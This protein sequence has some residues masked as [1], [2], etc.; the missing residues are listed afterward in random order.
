MD[1]GKQMKRLISVFL[2][3]VMLLACSSCSESGA[4][5]TILYALSS[6]PST[7]DPQFASE[8]SAK[9]VIN[10]VFEGLVRYD[11]KGEIIP[12]IAES[13]SVS[14]DGLTYTFNLKSDTEWFCPS[15]LKS[16][17]GEELYGRFSAET[18]KARDFVFAMRRAVMPSTASPNAHRLSVIANASEIIAGRAS[19]TLLGVEAKGDYTLE[20]RLA[21][22]CGDFLSRLTE[23]VCMPCNED[24]FNAMAGRYGLSSKYIMCNG[25]FYISAWDSETSLTIK[26]NKYYAGEQEVLPAS[27]AFSFD[28]S[29]ESVASKL[30]SGDVSAAVIS[31]DNVLPENASIVKESANTVAGFVFNC[32]DIY[33]KSSALRQ[34]LSHAIDP[35]VFADAEGN[36]A[37]QKGLVPASCKVGGYD[38]RSAVGSQTKQLGFD[39]QT[40]QKLWNEALSTLAVSKI[41]LTVLCPDWL[42]TQVRRQ[43]QLWQQTFGIALAVTVEVAS[44]ADIDKAV[45]SG[46]YQIALTGIDAS[47]ESA[48][49]FLEKF[50]GGGIFRYRSD[51]YSRIIDNLY[52]Y[53][54]ND[55][56]LEGCYAAETLLLQDAVCY[57]LYSLSSYFALAPDAADITFVDSES[58]VCFINAKRFD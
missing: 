6:S 25:P 45:S 19:E 36:A 20:I 49:D 31:S 17:I 48:I 39:A 26:K 15:S 29:S 54:D 4:G 56:A 10:N 30:A 23:S 46:N 35:S 11:S 8:T 13:W 3:S 51:D 7:L 16:E 32:A 14:A 28:S 50:D 55:A 57:P 1:G 43:L 42:E 22:K 12:G 21:E 24:F 40:A 37:A 52:T 34:A 38:Y 58:T 27:V 53:S 18:V 9:I 2:I 41:S 47:S 33:L 44:A 5:R